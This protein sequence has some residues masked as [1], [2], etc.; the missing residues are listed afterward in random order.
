MSSTT[1]SMPVKS[2][3]SRVSAKRTLPLKDAQLWPADELQLDLGNPRL[4]TGDEVDLATE[5]EVVET[6]AEI[7]ALDELVLSICTNGYLNLEPLIVVGP[8]TGPF[9]VLE[10]NRRLASIKLI[11][12]PAWAARL[13]I[14]VPQ[15]TPS[16]KK[17]ITAVL[18]YRVAD[19][20]DAREFI[21]FKHINGPQRWDAY[22]KAKYVTD[23][24]KTAN[25][26]V[27][28]DDIA[29]KMGD[30]NNTLRSY[31][32]AVLILEQAQAAKVWS[33]EDRPPT[34]G[35]FPFSHLYTAIQRLEYQQL[36]G[37][38]D[39]W[40]NTP[41]LKPI[42]AGKLKELGETLTYI[43]GSVSADR[44]SLIKSQNPDLRDLGE[45]MINPAARRA[46]RNGATLD[47]AR[48]EMKE[49]DSAFHDALV[50]ANLRLNRAI[51]LLVRYSGANSAIDSVIEEIYQQ[52]DTLKTMTEKKRSK[53][54]V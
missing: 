43:Y 26:K 24:Y 8:D 37:L 40:S 33:L 36:L 23:W 20:N 1:K 14:K 48:D 30:N 38:T 5:E 13:G 21:G 4:Q 16:V 31:I 34:R 46:L 47:R 18:V 41:P 54:R 28:I 3:A 32:Y 10:G 42:K 39:G 6:L 27:T 12:D 25:G 51:S 53:S 2:T 11:N 45:A 44:P 22:A 9:R 15:I 19:E 50:V 17:S 49:P 35:R 7:A 52:A 29:A